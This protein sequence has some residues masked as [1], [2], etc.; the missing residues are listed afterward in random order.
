MD[1]LRQG[2][3]FLRRRF[4][5]IGLIALLFGVLSIL[6]VSRIE[7]GYESSIQLMIERP[8][9]SPAEADLKPG[10]TQEPSFV[11]GQ[12]Y[13]LQSSEV[14]L[15]VL[16]DPAFS[17]DP[18]FRREPPTALGLM[19]RNGIARARAALGIPPDPAPDAD[20]VAAR[21]QAFALRELRRMIEVDR[22]GDSNVVDLSVI[23]SDPRKAAAL[24]EKIG[25]VYIADR[26]NAQTQTAIRASE[27]LGERAVDLQVKLAAAEDAVEA[28]KIQNNLIAGET[29][30]TL[31][32][33][34][35][36][37]LNSELIKTRAELAQRRAAYGQAL[38]LLRT[39]GDIQSLPVLQES[40]FIMALR[41]ELLA[42]IRRENDLVEQSGEGHL[43][44]PQVRT[45]RR[46]LE[47]QLDEE[48]GRR[49][50]M[51][52][53][54]VETLEAREELVDSALRAA[55]AQSGIESQSGVELRELER[56]AQA[57][58][59]LYERYLG[60]ASIAN[61]GASYLSSGI[62]LIGRAIVP[63]DPV[64]PP[65]KV[66]VV[67]GILF[68]ILVGVLYGILREALHRGFITAGQVERKLGLPVLAAIPR[69]PRKT[70][71][72]D[73]VINDPMSSYSE[74][75]R[76]L[77]HELLGGLKSS[78]A[79]VVLITSATADE[80]KTG[81]AAALGESALSAG[82]QVLLIDADLRRRG[83]T[84]VFGMQGERGLTDILRG[85]R[86]EDP[87]ADDAKGA[88]GL[89]VIP[90]GSRATNP[91]D[92]LASPAFQRFLQT[93]RNAYDLIILDGPPVAN[94]ADA[95]ILSR[96]SDTAAM[97]VRWKKTPESIVTEALKRLDA[98]KVGG[99]V[100]SAVDLH[101]LASYGETYGG[102][103]Q[104]NATRGPARVG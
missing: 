61:E 96:E 2:V 67:F 62:T 86:F 98:G 28:F 87:D 47:R 54:E 78:G 99:I 22:K 6:A 72:M 10:A 100:L 11:D 97:V 60:N 79:P 39:G 29:G 44:L 76:V 51:L 42:A 82:K 63:I 59:V 33:Q 41:T 94:I 4:V 95:S 40:E 64:Y 38:V 52:G 9:S 53:N 32:E 93:S 13:V 3:L 92:L 37:E 14:L 46:E 20:L 73:L 35:M 103:V 30:T 91:T 43:Q 70:T 26:I 90:A 21:E 27:W 55:N 5:S 58:K 23:A 80:G 56:I 69:L 104:D 66:F 77:R 75:V 89:F 81:L 74:A 8:P 18:D 31:S 24:A 57:H 84:Q 15:Q 71:L 45:K 65:T 85:G 48:V 7:K 17:D 102:Y 12:V 83:L 88:P 49:I 50:D 1:A 36:F 34:Q 19:V 25:S 16:Q 68:G 101:A